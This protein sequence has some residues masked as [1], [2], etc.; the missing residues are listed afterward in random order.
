[1]YRIAAD[2]ADAF[3]E[4]QARY[5]ELVATEPGLLAQYSYASADGEQVS[6][7]HVHTD[8]AAADAHL[9]LVGPVLL[10]RADLFA[11]VA[12]EVYGEPGPVIQGAL[13]RNAA[14]GVTVRVAPAATAAF[15]RL[16]DA[17]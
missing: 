14:D 4:L 5:T 11:N 12:I 9:Q 1:V 16:A 3:A 13:D 8:A 7:I 15:T 6:L 17:A 10:E 2:A